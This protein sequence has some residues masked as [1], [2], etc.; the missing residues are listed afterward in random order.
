MPGSYRHIRFS[1]LLPVLVAII[2]MAGGG[3]K[4]KE[5]ATPPVQE[6]EGP[7]FK[8][9]HSVIPVGGKEYV[10]FVTRCTSEAVKLEN[11]AIFDPGAKRISYD[12]FT[13]TTAYQVFLK[14]EEFTFPED[15]S[16]QKG[17]WTFTYKGMRFKDDTE[18]IVDVKDTIIY[19]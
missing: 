19:R 18:F 9:T 14:N 1:I 15:F 17:I 6:T 4:K 12:Y 7:V 8:V 2:L 10:Q 11:A 13:D 5:T 16:L 3:C